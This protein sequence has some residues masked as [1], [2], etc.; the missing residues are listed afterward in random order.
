MST[1][2]KQKKELQNP[3]SKKGNI[4][5]ELTESTQ[6]KWADYVMADD[7][8][9]NEIN[10][11]NFDLDTDELVTKASERIME[12]K[13]VPGLGYIRTALSDLGYEIDNHIPFFFTSIVLVSERELAGFLYVNVDGF[14]SNCMEESELQMILSWNSIK[15][16][17]LMEEDETSIRINVVLEEHKLTIYEPYSKNLLVL[18]SIYKNILKNVPKEKM[19]MNLIVFDMHEN[20]LNWLNEKKY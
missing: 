6:I 4:P 11:G 17:E 10:L 18:L 1:K 19:G 16:I 15:D 20:Y 9:S 14:Y 3:N 8:D 7:S 12:E 2:K 13:V 5:T